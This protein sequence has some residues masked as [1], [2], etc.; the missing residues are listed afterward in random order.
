M[1]ESCPYV[2]ADEA[3]TV[4][5]DLA[6]FKQAVDQVPDL[7]DQTPLHGHNLLS[8]ACE[9]GDLQAAWF[10]LLCGADPNKGIALD[11]VVNDRCLPLLRLLLS[12]G[13]DPNH[14]EIVSPLFLASQAGQA[15]AVRLLLQY[16]ADPNRCHGHLDEM[17]P[18]MIALLNRHTHCLP[19]LLDAAADS[20]IQWHGFPDL[21]A[22]PLVLE[23]RTT[24]CCTVGPTATELIPC[25]NSCTPLM[26]AAATGNTAAVGILLAH[27][28]NPKIADSF[29]LFPVDYLALSTCVHTRQ[30]IAGLLG[31]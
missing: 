4:L 25:E 11:L 29:G 15:R 17:P 23:Q 28:A 6:A 9:I 18:L 21:D 19:H 10:L 30:T 16:G 27:G 5:R 31:K 1:T 22:M 14:R 7:D 12:Y 3:L 20:N 2:Q 8:R 13:A 24:L 26:L